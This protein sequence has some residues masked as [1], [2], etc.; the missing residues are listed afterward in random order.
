MSCNYVCE[1]APISNLPHNNGSPAGSN[2][3]QSLERKPGGAFG[4]RKQTFDN[5]TDWQ[6]TAP[7]DPHDLASTPAP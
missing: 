6:A 1:G 3:D 2:V 4:N 7:A 5:P